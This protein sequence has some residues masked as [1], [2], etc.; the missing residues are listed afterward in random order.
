MGGMDMTNYLPYVT[1]VD[2]RDKILY[3]FMN[4]MN[5]GL[6]I[7]EDYINN[8]PDNVDDR[9]IEQLKRDRDR[10][11]RVYRSLFSISFKRIFKP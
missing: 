4:S 1:S 5:E 2:D 3:N 6:D 8:P 7:L 9:T 10:Y 11:C